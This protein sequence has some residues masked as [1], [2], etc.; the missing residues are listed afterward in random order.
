MFYTDNPDQA[1]RFG[2]VI[3]GFF[4]SSTNM[5]SPAKSGNPQD[6]DYEIKVSCPRFSVILTPCCSIGDKTLALTPLLQIN[7]KW[8]KNP[9]LRED[10]T[11]LNRPM[12]PRQAVPP[13]VWNGLPEEE[14]QRRLDH[15]T[16]VGLEFLEYFVYPPH[17]LLRKYLINNESY[18][19]Y[20]IDFRRISR[21]EC[22]QVAN[23]KQSPL[24][25]KLLQLAKE[26]RSELRF[27]LS[28]YFTRVP[29]EDQV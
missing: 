7:P 9:Y 26:T 14:R 22:S 2:D 8:L 21:V 10:L 5:S 3:S 24:E 29:K 6:L 15:R 4:L 20:C 19:H 16:G 17:D 18:H 13:D 28:K 25:A 12:T 27:K 1:L 23:P 11:N